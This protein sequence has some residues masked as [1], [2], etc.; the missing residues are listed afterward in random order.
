MKKI[1]VLGLGLLMVAMAATV[2][3]QPKLDLKISGFVDW[4]GNIYQNIPGGG[5]LPAF[6][7]ARQDLSSGDDPASFNKQGI[8][9][10]TAAWA[11]SRARLKFQA[12]YG[13]ELSG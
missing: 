11:N 13:K 1:L 9:D 5:N 6:G 2:Y 7:V 10:K 4:T 8:A 12:D 3:A